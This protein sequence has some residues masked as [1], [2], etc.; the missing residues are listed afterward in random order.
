MKILLEQKKIIQP[1]IEELELNTDLIQSKSTSIDML[2][3]GEKQRIAWIRTLVW[4]P[5]I[6]FLSSGFDSH[7][8]DNVKVVLLSLCL[9]LSLSVLCCTCCP[10]CLQV[11]C[12]CCHCPFC[13]LLTVVLAGKSHS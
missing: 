5:D 12:P 2:S 9:L 8:R 4:K 10:C 7:E 11:N 3:G 1:W 13:I 6:I